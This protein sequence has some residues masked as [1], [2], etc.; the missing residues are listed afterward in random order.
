MSEKV[1]NYK[2]N[3]LLD[4]Q[5]VELSPIPLFIEGRDGL[6]SIQEYYADVIALIESGED[7]SENVKAQE[8]LD[9]LKKFTVPTFN[10]RVE[11]NDEV[12]TITASP[13][14]EQISIKEKE[15]FNIQREFVWIDG[16]ETSKGIIELPYDDYDT[17]Y[18][19]KGDKA[20]PDIIIIAEGSEGDIAPY[21]FKENGKTYI[22]M[23]GFSG[24]GGTQSDPYLVSTP[25]D[26]FNINNNLSA[27]YEQV[28]NID[29]TNIDF[30]IIGPYSMGTGKEFLGYYNGNGYSL[31]NI[32]IDS[33]ET[34]I[35]VF[36]RP[37][38]EIINTFLK[39]VNIKIHGPNRAGLFAGYCY[40]GT[41]RN[42]GA[43]GVITGSYGNNMHGGGFTGGSNNVTIENCY[44]K[45]ESPLKDTA[46]FIGNISNET[47]IINCYA[48]SNVPEYGFQKEY[49]NFRNG[50]ITG[51]FYSRKDNE[52]NILEGNTD[53]EMKTQSTFVNWDF[54]NTWTMNSS[55]G[56]P[57]LLVYQ[58]GSSG[59][60]T[61]TGN[62]GEDDNYGT[63]QNPAPDGFMRLVAG[64]K[65]L[66][67]S[68]I[69]LENTGEL[70]YPYLRI[71][72]EQKVCVF[73]LKRLSEVSNQ[74]AYPLRV[75]THQDIFVFETNEATA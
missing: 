56:Y 20:N 37:K 30:Q 31:T 60:D 26:F 35:G 73:K 45:V 28:N 49:R 43:E 50:N 53:A 3:K 63:P 33:S 51:N 66:Y 41:I 29:F 15:V 74:D 14:T 62:E 34:M 42:C 52:G 12:A 9:L 2:I 25:E 59:G 71:I 64:G 18:V 70:P 22:V 36:A 38:G 46:G 58:G 47:N 72:A 67:V 32:S 55:D 68:V 1:F 8:Y 44:V 16:A 69:F 13:R 39:N 10:G 57:A 6:L 5:E 65:I 17:V 61:G 23:D 48:I 27:H 7:V 24:G 4:R 21:Y 19:T 11:V 54:V 75:I 40:G